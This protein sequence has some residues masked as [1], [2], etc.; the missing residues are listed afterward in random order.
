MKKILAAV[1]ATVMILSALAAIA[2]IPVSAAADDKFVWNKDDSTGDWAAYAVGGAY[3]KNEEDKIDYTSNTTSQS[4]AAKYTEEGFEVS[5]EFKSEFS[6]NQRFNI[7]TKKEQNLKKGISM[8]VRVNEFKY[9]GDMWFSFSVWD[10]PNI[11]QGNAT[12]EYGQGY[13]NLLRPSKTAGGDT[14]YAEG[15]DYPAGWYSCESFISDQTYYDYNNTFA[16][17]YNKGSATAPLKFELFDWGNDPAAG[18]PALGPKFNDD[19]SFEVTFVITYENDVYHLYVNGYEVNSAAITEYF[20]YRFSDGLAFIGFS[21]HGAGTDCTA[22]ATIIEYNG[23]V[24]TGTDSQEQ[25]GDREKRGE[26]IPSDTIVDDQ[27]ALLFNSLNENGDYK[28]TGKLPNPTK[29]K[30]TANTDGSFSLTPLTGF[31]SFFQVRPAAHASYEASDFPYFALL[32]RNFCTCQDATGVHDCAGSEEIITFYC[33]GKV[34]TGNDRCRMI[35]SCEYEYLPSETVD[36]NDYKLFI[37]DYSDQ[38]WMGLINYVQVTF[39][40]IKTGTDRGTFDLCYAGY[41]KS[42][43]AASDYADNYVDGINVCEHPEENRV[44]TDAIP[45]T[46]Q[47]VGYTAS[48]TC[49]DC[50]Y[51][52]ADAVVIPPTD[53]TWQA[54][55]AVP[56]TC[57]EDGWSVGRVCTVCN[58]TER[59]KDPATGHTYSDGYNGISELV[60]WKECLTCGLKDDTTEAEHTFVDGVC[61]GCAYVEGTE[62]CKHTNISDNDWTVT[63]PATCTAAGVK[64]AT[65]PDCQRTIEAAIPTI[66]HNSDGIIEAKD[67]TC[68]SKGS[69]EGRRCSMCF[70]QMV[71]PEDIPALGHT[72]EEIPGKLPTCT[73]PGLSD[74]I[75]CSVCDAIIEEQM[76]IEALGHSYEVTG[77]ETPAT[78]TTAGKKADETCKVCGAVKTGATIAATGH[79]YDNKDDADCNV[80]GEKRTVA[81]SETPTETP[82]EAPEEKKGCGSVAGISALAICATISL[83]GAVCFKKKKD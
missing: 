83:A 19:G 74:G 80:C 69:T 78:C 8:T 44:Y 33:A 2:V 53:H 39:N 28:E 76:E 17:G 43:D 51:V 3:S 35:A 41:F 22:S 73:D 42:F 65:C 14:I 46:C 21:L 11:V 60:H 72:E 26:L 50:G 70:L 77:T 62:I 59:E 81:N 23:E 32:L 55:D 13:T 63:R 57:T 16:F 75:K 40:Y 4:P 7:M 10:S 36:G 5:A 54:T 31:A 71:A 24:P 18:F 12:G 37:F 48:E 20:K 27:P 56:P 25:S 61:S 29:I 6:E 52:F 68:T 47:S 30:Y 49:G 66:P 38:N 79:K 82:T 9:E 15:K 1:L 58:K 34:L 45:A 67:P 64:N